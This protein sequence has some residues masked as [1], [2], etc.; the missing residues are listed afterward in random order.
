MLGQYL[1]GKLGTEY[2]WM[3]EFRHSLIM[4]RFMAVIL[5][6]K[7]KTFSILQVTALK[8]VLITSKHAAY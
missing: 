1:I 4:Y 3:T 8:Y 6:L 7:S 2:L 5:V